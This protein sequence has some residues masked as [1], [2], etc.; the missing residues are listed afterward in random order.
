MEKKKL[1]KTLKISSEVHARL[2]NFAKKSETIDQA[3]ERLLDI[4]E[5]K[6]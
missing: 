2:M 5:K 6:V 3:I 4:A 1:D